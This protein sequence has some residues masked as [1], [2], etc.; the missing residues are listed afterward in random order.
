MPRSRDRCS[1]TRSA[2][3]ARK[4]TACTWSCS[5]SRCFTSAPPARPRH[6]RD[7]GRGPRRA[8]HRAAARTGAAFRRVPGSRVR[9]RSDPD[10]D[11]RAGR[12]RL[13]VTLVVGEE[14]G[15]MTL[16]RLDAVTRRFGGL[17][18][19]D[20]VSLDIAA[21]GVTAIIGPNGAG[22]TTLFNVISGFSAPSAG[23]VEFAGNDI[24]GLGAEE[25]AKRGL[26]R[27]FQLVQLFEN[28]TVLE[29]VKVGQIGRAHG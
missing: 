1:C 20:H 5:T 19:V 26:V 18:A 11:L 13:T 24:T 27:T 10:P 23:R 17:V 4:S 8:G 29:N 9:R 12:T 7:R 25:I 2:S 15:H 14:G 16:L 6:R 28:L 22:K 3:S 21:G